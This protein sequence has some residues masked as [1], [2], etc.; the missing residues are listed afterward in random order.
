MRNMA[1]H[2]TWAMCD[3]PVSGSLSSPVIQAVRCRIIDAQQSDHDKPLLQFHEEYFR[4]P[5]S[6]TLTSSAN[7]GHDNR[8]QGSL[9]VLYRSP[10]WVTSD[11]QSKKGFP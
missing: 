3:R 6:S 7:A 10:S 2:S 5:K 11:L 1:L 8:F 9:P 4:D